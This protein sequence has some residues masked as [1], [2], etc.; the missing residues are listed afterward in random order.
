MYNYL[1]KLIFQNINIV[2]DPIVCHT[3]FDSL[4]AHNS[5]LE[6]CL[7]NQRNTPLD[8]FIKTEN[9]DEASEINVTENPIKFE[10]PEVKSE[11][12]SFIEAKKLD[13]E[14]IRQMETSVK[15]ECIEM[16]PVEEDLW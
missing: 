10:F 5:F 13:I 6:Q 2:K 1:Y 15:N 9:L 12:D 16:K 4:C 14:E 3:C 8:L 7:E 11:N